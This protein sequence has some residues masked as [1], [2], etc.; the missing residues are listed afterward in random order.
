MKK[1]KNILL[2][3]S[4]GFL[5]VSLLAQ[6]TGQVNTVAKAKPVKNTF[7]SVWLIDN[8]TVMVPVKGTLEF[9]IQHRFG[10]VENGKKDVWGIFAPSNI[11]LG[12]NYSPI[13]KLYLGAG[14]TKEKIQIDL[15]A[16]YALL[17]QTPGTMPVSVTY[18]GNMVI[19]TRDD[20]YF[21][22]DVD[23]L[24]YFNQLLIARKIS[25]KFSAQIA[26]SFS[27]FNNVE[28]YIDSKGEE[29]PKMNNGHFAISVAGRYKIT[30]RSAIIAGYDQP[31][32]QHPTNNPHPNICFGYEITTSSHA[33]QIIVGNYYSILPQYN[34][35]YNPNDYTE[36]QFLIGFNISR[37][38]NF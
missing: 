9:D 35:V 32:T 29:Q 13:N 31:L 4:S 26:P 19:D 37:L 2:F 10:T 27:W 24:S 20:S 25:D 1:F 23:R 34:N 12:M 30:P 36:G 38:W 16:K 8:Q 22:N 3:L 28:A 17:Q 18:F 15:N 33:F 14:L 7:E 11:R 21:E 5:S 6:D